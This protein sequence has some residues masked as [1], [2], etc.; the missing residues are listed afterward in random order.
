MT[1][2]K[3][4]LLCAVLAIGPGATVAYANT[5]QPVEPR[6]A[7]TGLT[8]E[9]EL[10]A[11]PEVQ[12]L[13]VPKIETPRPKPVARRAPRSCETRDL[14][15]YG[16]QVRVCGPPAAPTPPERAAADLASQYR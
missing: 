10:P 11:L 3:A 4:V 8:P 6:I 14:Q 12:P 2:A 1:K 15:L 7:F 9:V 13:T 16:G 5:D